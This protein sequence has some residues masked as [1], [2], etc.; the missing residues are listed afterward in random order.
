MPIEP[1]G[2]LSLR[3]D[4]LIKQLSHLWGQPCLA[5]QQA[6]GDAR[7]AFPSAPYGALFLQVAKPVLPTPLFRHAKRRLAEWFLPL[8]KLIPYHL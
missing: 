3:L 7:P 1:E 2:S 5:C 4:A 8:A 6:Q